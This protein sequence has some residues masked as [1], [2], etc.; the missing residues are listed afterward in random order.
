M[1][2][3]EQLMTGLSTWRNQ[4]VSWYL[5]CPQRA[6]AEVG[7]VALTTAAVVES[8]AGVVFFMVTLP[9]FAGESLVH[10]TCEQFFIK[11][12]VTI[13]WGL[14]TI[15]VTNLFFDKVYGSAQEAQQALADFPWSFLQMNER[16]RNEVEN[17]FDGFGLHM[18]DGS[19]PFADVSVGGDDQV[20]G[21]IEYDYR[22]RSEADRE[23]DLM[24][25]M[26]DRRLERIVSAS[27]AKGAK[28]LIQDIA[29]QEIMDDFV[30][31][32]ADLCMFL[33]YKTAWVYAFGPRKNEELDR[34]PFKYETCCAIRNLRLKLVERSV[35]E[36]LQ[37]L[38]QS[39]KIYDQGSKNKAVIE[40]LK[41]VQI[42]GSHE[43][44]NSQLLGPVWQEAVEVM[45]DIFEGV[46]FLIGNIVEDNIQQG[47]LDVTNDVIE[48]VLAKT[49]W[50]YA[51]G[52]CSGRQIL[53]V[54]K[55]ETRCSIER[56]RSRMIEDDVLFCAFDSV[57]SYKA[58]QSD[59][60]KEI[61][62]IA[63][64]ELPEGLFFL[65]SW[66]RARDILWKQSRKE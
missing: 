46:E 44:Q 41:E 23:Q 38:F 51:L 66:A 45:K 12:R 33:V 5:I 15:F 8:V 32:D 2:L 35:L 64:N 20:P 61:R 34:F 9:F 62:V 25:R 49:V 59:L 30:E 50:T 26:D 14:S 3:T 16:D 11:C 36:E 55:P 7:F 58:C 37:Q 53:M 60:M 29:T 18:I 39:R 40:L 4:E 22:L 19:L 48:F 47:F 17:G 21:W 31:L 54:L 24:R 42:A 65:Q 10:E 1:A 13:Y 57:E 27:V 28:T 6:V 56:L 63:I 52:P 43:V